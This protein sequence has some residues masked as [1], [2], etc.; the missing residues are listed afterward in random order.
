M[1]RIQPV[2]VNSFKFFVAYKGFQVV[3]DEV[4]LKGLQKCKSLGA[5][6]MIHAENGETVIEGQQIMIELGIIGPEGH[7]LSRPPAVTF[8]KLL[9][10]CEMRLLNELFLKR[11]V[12]VSLKF[13]KIVPWNLRFIAASSLL[14]KSIMYVLHAIRPD[15]GKFR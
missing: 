9:C 1:T 5:L 3:D 8:S 15:Q 13:S 11:S 7:A 4:L 2:G 6:A 12:K 10:Y 14:T